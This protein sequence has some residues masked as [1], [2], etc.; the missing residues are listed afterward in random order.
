MRRRVNQQT[1]NKRKKR[2][3]LLAIALALLLALS[4]HWNLEGTPWGIINCY[5]QSKAYIET[6]FPFPVKI[7]KVIY[8][9]KIDDYRALCYP[10]DEPDAI[11][12]IGHL[13]GSDAL[14]NDYHLS[15]C[16]LQLQDHYST[17]LP[18][19]DLSVQV[20][21]DS[22]YIFSYTHLYPAIEVIPDIFSLQDTSWLN[23]RFDL[24]MDCSFQET[25]TTTLDQLYDLCCQINQDF[26]STEQIGERSITI[27]WA[28]HTV[29]FL[30]GWQDLLADKESFLQQLNK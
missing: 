22:P 8:A 12:W 18:S 30:Y 17:A 10:L 13:S 28:D 11:F 24:R 23:L 5:F 14:E 16:K 21:D 26:P 7:Q 15:K 20:F 2:I 27:S 9:V 1:R 3:L 6:T 25:D 19:V 4:I 29:R